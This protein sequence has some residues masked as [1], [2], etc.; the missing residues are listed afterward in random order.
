MGHASSV[1]SWRDVSNTAHVR[2]PRIQW[3]ISAKP[4][5][6]TETARPRTQYARFDQ[7]CRRPAS[8]GSENRGSGAC[9][10]LSKGMKPPKDLQ[11]RAQSWRYS[12]DDGDGDN[13][14]PIHID[15]RTI[16]SC[17][18]LADACSPRYGGT[19][20]DHYD[21]TPR[22]APWLFRRTGNGNRAIS[23]TAGSFSGR[24]IES[25]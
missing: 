5:C 10:R 18:N 12:C 1:S 21:P 14:Q 17:W 6:P 3:R 7:R 20:A 22:R 24:A 15:H 19:V 9:A 13:P 8:G 4:K 2:E 16:C 23:D 11:R 25:A